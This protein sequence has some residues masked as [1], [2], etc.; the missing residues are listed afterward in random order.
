MGTPSLPGLLALVLLGS[1]CGHAAASLEEQV[2]RLAVTTS[3]RDSGLMDRLVPIFEER[4]GVRVDIIAAG[5]GAA[6]KLGERGDVDVLLVHARA[7]EDAFM[8]AGHGLR[9]ED[10]MVNS[11]EI[12]G[13]VDDPAG[14]RGHEAASALA[15]IAATGAAFVSR[16]DESGTHRRELELWEASGA[17]P[18]RPGYV[19]S[20]QGMGRTLIMADQMQAYVLADRGTYLAF[21][22]KI[23]LEPLIEASAVLE[24]PY[25]VIAVASLGRPMINEGLALSFVDFLISPEAQRLV[26]DYEIDGDS[27]FRPLRLDEQG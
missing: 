21:R 7:A 23:H 27:L 9:R 17:A 1:S 4:H 19:E 15:R 5:T 24:N 10:V 11:F 8:A 12:L 25:G 3:T 2:L 6:L 16:A 20:G 13:P 26:R 22:S 18:R 14:V